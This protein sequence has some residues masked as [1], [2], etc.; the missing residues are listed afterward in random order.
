MAHNTC[1]AHRARARTLSLSV[2]WQR[3]IAL[4]AGSHY[5]GC[6][7]EEEEERIRMGGRGRAGMVVCHAIDKVNTEG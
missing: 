2:G 1:G 7:F 6:S 3:V 4:I 5:D